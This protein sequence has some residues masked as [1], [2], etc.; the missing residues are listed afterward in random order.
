MKVAGKHLEDVG[1]DSPPRA[2]AHRTRIPM[3]AIATVVAKSQVA[4]EAGGIGG[5]RTMRQ[6]A[7]HGIGRLVDA[8]ESVWI[9]VHE[10][11]DASNTVGVR[12]MGDVDEHE[13]RSR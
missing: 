6:I 5:A 8:G 1:V 12:T 9:A 3:P 13:A 7:G 2:V 4:G 11:A 10:S